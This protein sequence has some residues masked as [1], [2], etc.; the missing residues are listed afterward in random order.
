VATVIT[1]SFIRKDGEL[2]SSNGNDAVTK[3]TD[4]TGS[5][6]NLHDAAG[7]LWGIDY[8]S[9]ASSAFDGDNNW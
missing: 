8:P 1:I 3:M 2:K 4:N 5:T 7:R 6:T 9:G